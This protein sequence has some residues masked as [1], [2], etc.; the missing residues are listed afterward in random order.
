LAKYTYGLL[1]LKQHQKIEEEGKKK[2]KDTIGE[3]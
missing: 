2:K 3:I 1:P